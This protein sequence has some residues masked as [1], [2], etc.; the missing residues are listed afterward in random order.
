VSPP[1][2]DPPAGTTR[3]SEGNTSCP[4]DSITVL[5]RV[6]KYREAARIAVTTK[7]VDPRRNLLALL[8]LADA[9]RQEPDPTIRLWSERAIWPE[10]APLLGMDDRVLYPND[11]FT[12]AQL[13]LRTRGYV[14][15]PECRST[16]ATDDELTKWRAIRRDEIARLQAHERAVRRDG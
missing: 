5:E 2:N 10:A 13:R 4:E 8:D 3:G 1:T 6:A 16:L 12:A 9:A 7:V 15:C 11:S 14:Q